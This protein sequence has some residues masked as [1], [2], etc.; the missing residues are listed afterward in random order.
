MM[1][2]YRCRILFT[3]RSKLDGHCILQ[4]KEI[5][6]TSALFQLV[7]AFYTESEEHRVLVKEIIETVHR[8]TFAVEL[9]AKLLENGMGS[10]IRSN[11]WP[12][13]VTRKPPSKMKIRLVPSKTGRTAKQLTIIISIRC[14]P[15]I[16]SLRNS[17]I[18]CGIYAFC[19]SPASLPVSLLTGS[20]SPL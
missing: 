15:C 4:L 9:A 2:K 10:Y 17:R 11:Y 16:L 1:L 3:T 7:S 5:R 6:E 12:N 20:G 18:S 14:F 8:H 19:P 13:S